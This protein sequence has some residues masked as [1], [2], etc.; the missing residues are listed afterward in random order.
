MDRLPLEE[1]VTFRRVVRVQDIWEAIKVQMHGVEGEIRKA[2]CFSK[3]Y[4]GVGGGGGG[5]RKLR[6]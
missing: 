4:A 3:N 2:D 1:G 6:H 5:G